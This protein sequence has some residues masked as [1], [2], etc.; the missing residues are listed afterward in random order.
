MEIAR[1]LRALLLLLLLA[2][3][4]AKSTT[5]PGKERPRDPCK[6]LLNKPD[7]SDRYYL[8]DTAQCLAECRK[9]RSSDSCTLRNL[10]RFWVYYESYL[11]ENSMGTVDKPFVKSLIQNIS[12]DTT[13]DLLFSLKL[14]QIPRQVMVG[15]DKP[16]DRVRLPKSIFGSLA[17]N[18]PTVRLAITVLDISSG[19]IFKVR[20]NLP[21][22]WK[23]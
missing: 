10:E 7:P 15:E 19:N 2:A 3:N 17:S 13:E 16:S 1:G 9:V 5:V 4:G 12:T 22:P 11:A 8:N 20:S 23:L 21:M 6:S 14:S 18:R